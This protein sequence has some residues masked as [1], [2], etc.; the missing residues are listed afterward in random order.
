MQLIEA[1]PSG[2]SAG[3]TWV[4]TDIPR[5]VALVRERIQLILRGKQFSIA[6]DG[7]KPEHMPW[8][9]RRHV[10]RLVTRCN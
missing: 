2:M 4:D 5:V 7:G 1:L 8:K 9:V 6:I 10:E 3:R